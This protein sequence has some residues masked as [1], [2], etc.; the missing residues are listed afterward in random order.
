[1]EISQII[2]K[3]VR[4]LKT[5]YLGVTGAISNLKKKVENLSVHLISFNFTFFRYF[6]FVKKHYI[7]NVFID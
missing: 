2:D 3:L 1:M 7:N 4:K 6:N 5:G